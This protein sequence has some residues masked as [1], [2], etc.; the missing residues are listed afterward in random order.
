MIG[1]GG[2]LFDLCALVWW[3]AGGRDEVEAIW[4]LFLEG[5]EA[6]TCL[7]CYR[8]IRHKLPSRNFIVE[9]DI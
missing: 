2:T 9:V 1:S 6:V 4:L 3:D 5:F 7:L 8:A